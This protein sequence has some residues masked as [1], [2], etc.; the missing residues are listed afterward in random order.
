MHAVIVDFEMNQKYSTRLEEWYPWEIIEIGAVKLDNT[1]QAVSS[2]KEYVRPKDGSP[3][4]PECTELTGITNEMVQ[5][6]RE[7]PQVIN[8]FVKWCSA[9][10]AHDFKIFSWGNNDSYQ[11][12]RDLERHSLPVRTAAMENMLFCWYDFQRIYCDFHSLSQQPSLVQALE[13]NALDFAGA[14]HDALVDASNTARL[15]AHF[16]QHNNINNVRKLILQGKR[17][18]QQRQQDLRRRRMLRRRQ[19]KEEASR[20]G[21]HNK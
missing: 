19:Q 1:F 12:K 4:V 21:S 2:F 5:G 6:A 13:T 9:G 15:I 7:L 11:L 20:P 3:I 10:G 18:R 16:T 14:H 8:H 17:F